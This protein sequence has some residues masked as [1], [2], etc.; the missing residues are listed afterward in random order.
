MERPETQTSAPD[1]A[2]D[3]KRGPRVQSLTAEV[4][5]LLHHAE[6]KESFYATLVQLCRQRFEASVGRVAWNDRGEMRAAISHDAR[7]ARSMARRFES[8]YLRPLAEEV[9]SHPS[10]EPKLKR[11]ERGDQKMT[12]AS[13]PLVD[14]ATGS[15]AGSITL[16]IAG[17]EQRASSLLPALDGVAA[18]ASALL[19]ASFPK[20][21][22]AE[23]TGDSPPT[24]PEQ[25]STTLHNQPALKA[26]AKASPF[27]STKEFGFSLVN[28]LCAQLQAEQVFF[29]VERGQ[30]IVI[31]AISGVPDFKASSPGVDAVR[32]SMEECLDRADTCVAQTNRPA[33]SQSAPIHQQWSMASRNSCVCSIPLK[34]GATVAGIVSVR[35][36]GERPF[37]KEMLNQV[38]Q[39]FTGYG[40][41]LRTVERAN[42]SPQ[43]QLKNAITDSMRHILKSGTWARRVVLLTFLCGVAWFFFGTM[44]YRPVCRTRVTAA[45]LQHFSAPFD[46]KLTA[47][48]VRPGQMVKAGQVLVE[49]DTTDLRFER[50][51]LLREIEATRVDLRQAIGDNDLPRA[52]LARSRINVLEVQTAGLDRRISDAVVRAPADGTVVL[53]DLEQRVG[54]LFSLGDEILQ[55]AGN[56]DWLLEIEIPDDI[57][58]FVATKQT[59]TFAASSFPTEKQAFTVRH[60][61]GA[62]TIVEQ[63]NVF[64]ARAPLESRPAWMRTGMEGTARLNTTKRPIW[65]VALHRV[66]DWARINFWV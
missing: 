39:L 29:G 50:N 5:N 61:D 57:A 36:S 9:E 25:A 35:R 23:V 22:V 14:A 47:V 54:Q 41:A 1:A 4:G 66:V 12:L 65:W 52:A 59:G 62:A 46:G 24:P 11:Y 20:K 7:V 28:S 33:E 63:R 51:S 26:L 56:G 48:H 55:F 6:S 32:Q 13:A 21:T 37:T 64:I 31:E 38:G 8:D 34:D 45:D 16:L 42:R 17:S 60:I 3:P 18:V 49:F 30:K 15:C 40:A 44:T 19:V 2:S 53:S 10:P 43:S 58:N 27:S